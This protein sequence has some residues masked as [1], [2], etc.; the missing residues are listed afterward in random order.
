MRD[1][2]DP[3]SSL[4]LVRSEGSS[5]LPH[6]EENFLQHFFALRGVDEDPPDESEDAGREHVV[7][8]G[9]GGLVAA[10]DT[11]QQVGGV[12]CRGPVFGDVY[13]VD[14]HLDKHAS[15]LALNRM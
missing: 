11:H 7:E 5:G 12:I 9:E 10:G 3:T 8:V 4:P 2:E 15:S 14:N 13:T 1:R 6:L